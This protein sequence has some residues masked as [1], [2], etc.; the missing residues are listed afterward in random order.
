MAHQNKNT[1]LGLPKRGKV[2]VGTG[3]ERGELELTE[4]NIEWN[5]GEVKGTCG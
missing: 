5:N 2:I 3:K 4:R 1:G